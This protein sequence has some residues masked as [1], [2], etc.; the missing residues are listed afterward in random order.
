MTDDAQLLQQYAQD[1]SEAAFGDLV[2]RHIDLVYSA[3]L[4]VLNGD[5]PLAQDV[6]QTVFIDLARKAGSLPSG[7]KL[8]GWLH[9]DTFYKAATAVRA[10]RR[11]KNR[12]QTAVQMSAC[13]ETP[14]L[15]WEPLAPKLDESL[16]ELKRADRDILVLRFLQRQDL[17]SVGA[18][19][20]ISED[21]AQKRVTRALEKLRAVLRRRGAVCS[22]AT[23]GTLLAAEAVTSAP[24]GLALSVST[25]ALATAAAAGTGTAFTL[26]KLIAM[27]KI[28]AGLLGALLVAGV[29]TPLVLQHQAQ[30]KLRHDNAALRAQLGESATENDALSNALA[31]TRGAGELSANQMRD[32]LR[33]RGEVG[34]LRQQTNL[35]GQLRDKNRR[36]QE[37]LAQ[38]QPS[39]TS[40]ADDNSP[41]QA[42][43]VARLIDAKSYC[44][45]M[46]LY[47]INNQGLMPT[48]L[49]QTLP[50]LADHPP[51]QTN[52]F[53]VLFHGAIPQ[54]DAAH[55]LNP[56]TEPILLRSPPW[57]TAEGKWARVYGFMDGH[58]EIHVTS[59]G[60]FADWEK[61]HLPAP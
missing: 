10:E 5:R 13:D 24:A 12:E 32:L 52:Q 47:A 36:L 39:D 46:M 54:S 2:K 23:L 38:A 53:E 20:G 40:S 8:A 41:E 31:R 21:A 34:L 17:R 4:R 18:A 30:L 51:T 59:D 56:E 49:E 14:E 28:K 43:A 44:L 15:A 22:A 11:R 42:Q 19:L 7:V 9:R 37:A 6:T 33:L 27:T 25:T 60:N 26:L 35:L 61:P 3:A 29:A 58:T 57:Q 16:D 48:N 50:Y 55:P 45:G 1:H